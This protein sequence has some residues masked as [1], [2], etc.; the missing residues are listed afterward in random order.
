MVVLMLAL[1]E[2]LIISSMTGRA[3]TR[4]GVK[5]PAVTGHEIFER[6]LRVQQNT[7]EQLVVFVPALVAY[8]WLV[9][10]LWAAVLGG[11][12]IV[13]RALYAA[14][15]VKDPAKRALGMGL[16]FFPSLVL[17]VGALRAAIIA[18]P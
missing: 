7:V 18:L 9:S 15:Y 10:D 12:W 2:Y 13:G 14:G 11:V 3:R 4:Y 1:V 8:A 5:A 6:W 16:T 17:V